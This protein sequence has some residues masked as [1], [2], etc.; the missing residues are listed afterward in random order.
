[1]TTNNEFDIDFETKK[2]EEIESISKTMLTLDFILADTKK[3]KDELNERLNAL[4]EHKEEG[5]KTYKIGRYAITV[6]SGKIFSLDK[7]EY[8]VVKNQFTKGLNPVK[9]KVSYEV[10]RETLRKIEVYGNENDHIL[11]DK[12]ISVKPS[13]ISV[14][15]KAAS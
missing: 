14:S 2:N 4:L 8:E 3:I 6:K 11:I 10:D 5:Q 15:V 9:E 7:E 13:K 1:M 12:L